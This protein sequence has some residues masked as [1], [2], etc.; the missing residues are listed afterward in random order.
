MRGGAGVSLSSPSK[1][2]PRDFE[3]FVGANAPG[4][5]E[6]TSS[7]RLF[8]ALQAGHWPAHFDCAAPQAWQT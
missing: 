4:G 2:R 6:V 8:Q 5:R 1:A 7:T 3:P